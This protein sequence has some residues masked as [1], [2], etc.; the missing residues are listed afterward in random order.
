VGKVNATWHHRHPMPKNATLE[1]R[2]EWHQ[3]HAA[4]CACRTIPATVLRELSR[5]GIK[6]A[7]Q[8]R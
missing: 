2:V 7:R 4:A 3:A 6:P 1:E 5:R 8:G